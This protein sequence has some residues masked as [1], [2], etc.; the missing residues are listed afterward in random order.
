VV[1][2]CSAITVP[3]IVALVG[4]VT[5]AVRVAGVDE[6]LTTEAAATQDCF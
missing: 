2:V 1:T 6:A 5:V 4:T 3:V